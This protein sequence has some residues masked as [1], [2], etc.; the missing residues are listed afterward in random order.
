MYDMW[1]GDL[2][3]ENTSVFCIKLSESI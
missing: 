2:I 1:E 3:Q